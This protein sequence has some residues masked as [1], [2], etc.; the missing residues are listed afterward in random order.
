MN[1][2][3]YTFKFYTCTIGSLQQAYLGQVRLTGSSEQTVRGV[4]L[5]ARSGNTI[6]WGYVCI[7][8]GTPKHHLGDSVCRQ[9]G[10]TAE[11]TDNQ[12]P[13]YR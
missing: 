3:F 13:P 1:L 7:R 10:Y 4:Q 5:Y 8:I 2:N 12:S 9:L 6:G 11:L